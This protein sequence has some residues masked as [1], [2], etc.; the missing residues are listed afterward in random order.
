MIDINVDVIPTYV[1]VF[2]INDLNLNRMHPSP[3][4]MIDSHDGTLRLF[5]VLLELA[6]VC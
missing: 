2:G 4:M 6:V 1:H 3:G 5:L